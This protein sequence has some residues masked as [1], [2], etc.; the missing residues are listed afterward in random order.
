[1]GFVQ[2]AMD[3]NDAIVGLFFIMTI[4]HSKISTKTTPFAM[5][6]DYSTIREEREVLFT[7]H[8][9][10]RVVDIKQATKN[11]RLWEIQLAITSDNDPQLVTLIN[12]IKEEIQGSTGWHRMDQLMLKVGNFDQVEELYDELLKNA[13]DD[14]DRRIVYNQMGWL[15]R[16][17]GKY[18]EAATFYQKSLEIRRETLPEDDPL[19]AHI[20]NNIGTVYR[21]MNDYSTAFQFYE[22]S[23]KIKELS[24]PPTHADLASS[25]NNICGVYKSMKQYSK[26]LEL[27]KKTMDIDKKT[28]PPNHPDLAISYNNISLVYSDMRNYS[29]ALEFYD[30]SIKIYEQ[31]MP[32]NHPLLATSYGNIGPVWS[33]LGD[34]SKA[35][36]FLEKALR[37]QQMSL[38]PTHPFIK[39][40][41]HR[42]DLVKRKR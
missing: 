33:E 25:Y 8:T 2:C 13:S 28:L 24:L 37:V 3:N 30:K 29:K 12:H 41:M 4:Y 11:S 21:Y 42:I 15:K 10:F 19:L 34:Y 1:M 35:L 14:S 26:S 16:N 32:P 31:V 20:Y 22:K 5:I 23:L 40:T 39:E 9:I 7:M 27:Y 18:Q 38:P 6:D 36:S 17:Q